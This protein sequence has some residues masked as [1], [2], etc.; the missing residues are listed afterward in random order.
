[1]LTRIEIFT[2][3]GFSDSLGERLKLEFGTVGVNT[4]S[5][6]CVVN[7]YKIGGEFARPGSGR[8]L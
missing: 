5:K 8:Y 6:V 1:M 4:V 2:R 7:V 3:P